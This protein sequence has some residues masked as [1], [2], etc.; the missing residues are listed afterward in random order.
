MILFVLFIL[1]LS[2]GSLINQMEIKRIDHRQREQAEVIQ[3]NT[4]QIQKLSFQIEQ[5]TADIRAETN[6][7]S[8]LYALLDVSLKAQ[9]DAVPGTP[10]DEKAQ[11]K[12][13][14]LDNQIH[15]TAC[16]G[17]RRQ[18]VYGPECIL[19]VWRGYVNAVIG[20]QKAGPAV[21]ERGVYEVI[22]I[23]A[24]IGRS[25]KTRTHGTGYWTAYESKA[26]HFLRK[27]DSLI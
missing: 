16:G 20:C 24:V 8:K 23:F 12:I 15:S 10:A 14:A 17:R 9:A 26:L 4:E 22:L 21:T 3:Q 5:L 27:K 11:R 13:I 25:K 1:L 18:A 2:V 6:R 7:L 19:L